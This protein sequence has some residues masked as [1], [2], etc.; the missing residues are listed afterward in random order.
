MAA[1]EPGPRWPAGKRSSRPTCAP[2]WNARAAVAWNTSSASRKARF[3]WRRWRRATQCTRSWRRAPTGSA[4]AAAPVDARG[5]AERCLPRH[6]YAHAAQR[7]ADIDDVLTWLRGAWRYLAGDEATIL[8]VEQRHT[9]AWSRGTLGPLIFGAKADLVRLRRDRDGDY[10]EIVDYKTGKGQSFPYLPPL[11]TRIAM[12]NLLAH[13]LAPQESPRLV[14]TYLWL[15]TGQIESIDVDRAW[16]NEHWITVYAHIGD[17]LGEAQWP[18]R[19]SHLCSF[20]P[21]YQ[22]LCYPNLAGV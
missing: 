9:W 4:T 11:L 20:C 5:I 18:E 21:Y 10:V 8:A 22:T 16:L 14:F 3:G 13:R 1:D 6:Q 2:I 12:N 19:A 15:Q 17:L 7:E